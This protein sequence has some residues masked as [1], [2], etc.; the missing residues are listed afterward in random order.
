MADNAGLNSLATAVSVRVVP[1]GTA[2]ADL[3]VAVAA[4]SVALVDTA[5]PGATRYC[6][7]SGRTQSSSGFKP[8][9]K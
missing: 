6:A 4:L 1:A 7:T 8:A 2:T 5:R 9:A 3:P